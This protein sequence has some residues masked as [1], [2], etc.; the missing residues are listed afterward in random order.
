MEPLN[1]T[2]EAR[3]SEIITQTFTDG[4][5][6]MSLPMYQSRKV[7]DEFGN[8]VDSP[9]GLKGIPT[10]G[11]YYFSYWGT[12][13]H[14]D[15][16]IE[17][18]EGGFTASHGT[19]SPCNQRYGVTMRYDLDNK[20]RLFYTFGF[21]ISGNGFSGGNVSLPDTRHQI[22]YPTN[23]TSYV[24]P[25]FTNIITLVDT[26]FTYVTGV[27]DYRLFGN[28]NTLIGSMYFPKWGF[29][30][31]GNIPGNLLAING[32]QSENK[33]M[34]YIAN[35]KRGHYYPLLFGQEKH[36]RRNTLSYSFL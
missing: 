7:T 2:V 16:V 8:I 14:Q 33:I 6:L 10:S 27:A 11:N 22:I 26:W 36:I 24:N 32:N 5:I 9:D 34:Q 20:K 19:N 23:G 18:N 17:N 12:T 31:N 13:T 29:R 3:G 1:V 35:N 21:R 30:N 4:S 28:G 15:D 25:P